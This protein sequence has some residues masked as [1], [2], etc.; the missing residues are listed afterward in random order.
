M[1]FGRNATNLIE[2]LSEQGV[3]TDD[4]WGQIWFEDFALGKRIDMS[5]LG[6]EWLLNKALQNF[7]TQ[8]HGPAPVSQTKSSD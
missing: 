7:Q 5:E 6:Q 1:P 3:F 8:F 4:S 2:N